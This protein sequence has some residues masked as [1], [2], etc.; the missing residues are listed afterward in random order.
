LLGGDLVVRPTFV[1]SWPLGWWYP[2]PRLNRINRVSIPIRCIFF[3]GNLSRKNLQVK[4]AW[5]GAIWDG[6]P[7]RKFSRLCMSEDKVRTKDSCWS[8]GTIYNPREL[9]GVCTLVWEW[10]GCYSLIAFLDEDLVV[11]PALQ[12][13]SLGTRS[14][15]LPRRLARRGLGRS[16][17]LADFLGKCV[18]ERLWVLLWVPRS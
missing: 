5:L 13:C 8:T 18:G 4:C 12:V 1:I 16:P 3:F 7:T 17:C 14:F 2:G 10:T 6:W 15:A 9:P 11:R